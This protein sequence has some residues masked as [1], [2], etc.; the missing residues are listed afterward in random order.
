[1][2]TFSNAGGSLGSAVFLTLLA[3]GVKWLRNEISKRKNEGSMESCDDA[4]PG[5]YHATVA[6]TTLKKLLETRAYPHVVLDVRPFSDEEDPLPED[7]RGAIRLP[8]DLVET[9]LG[10]RAS[11]EGTFPQMACPDTLKILVCVGSNA[12]QEK[13]A[14]AAANSIGYQRTLAVQGSLPGYRAEQHWH[15]PVLSYISRDG[16]ALVLSDA[17]SIPISGKSESLRDLVTLID[18]RRSDERI[19]YGSIKGSKHIPGGYY[20]F[21]CFHACLCDKNQ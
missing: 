8:Y 20:F 7:L 16:L 19:L 11:W 14:A 1:M 6:P 3:W 13:K 10:S 15:K 5:P 18:V 9:V 12:E 17:A 21:V 4:T 2:P